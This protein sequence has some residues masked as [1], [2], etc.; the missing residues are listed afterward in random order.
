[1]SKLV[2]YYRTASGNCPVE[3]FL[4][5]LNCKEQEKVYWVLGLLEDL[6]CVPAEY[7]K[8]LSNTE[9]IW[10]CR[11]QTG[12]N[13]FRISSFFFRGDT[14]ILTHGYR[15]KSRKTDKKEIQKAETY[16][17]DYLKRHG[18]D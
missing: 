6:E 1:M 2:Q 17:K 16:R 4:Q 12:G 18:K 13:A 5:S 10:E 14:V 8:K 15:K 3:V 11:V 9:E 7:F